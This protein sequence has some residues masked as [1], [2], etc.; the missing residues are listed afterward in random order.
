MFNYKE[1]NKRKGIY[2]IT[3]TVNAKC[4]IGSSYHCLYKRL[5]SHLKALSNN[6]HANN[7]LQHAWNKYGEK[8]FAFEIL[9]F[10]DEKSNQE[11]LQL[12]EHYIELFQSYI[13][14]K[15]YNIFRFCKNS[16]G[17]KWSQEA[18]NRRKGFL[19]GRKFSDKHKKKISESHTGKKVKDITKEKLRN[20]PK[21]NR[22]V[23]KLTLSGDFVAEFR[24]LSEAAN[25]MN[26]ISSRIGLI[27]SRKAKTCRGFTFMWKD[28]YLQNNS[29]NRI[30][31]GCTS[32][33][34]QYSIKGEYLTTFLS[35][36]EA[37]E[38]IKIKGSNSNISACCNNR[39]KSA[40]GF[41]WKYKN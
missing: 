21:N 23:V 31:A 33:I 17:N 4:Y 35:V 27:C 28:D 15:G 6:K 24:N 18:V 5:N 14:N 2:K 26:T 22:G 34:E 25:H 19:K 38:Y 39:K 36:K 8:K 20:L 13:R 3:N 37:E 9:E 29:F 10:C 7:Y 12:E 1:T 41:I 40:Y 32:E 16:S 30:V 11:V